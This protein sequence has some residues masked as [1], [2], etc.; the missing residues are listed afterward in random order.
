MGARRFRTL[1]V[2]NRRGGGEDAAGEMARRDPKR[3][4]P[5]R[6]VIRSVRFTPDEWA[7][8]LGKAG[9]ARL[10]PARFLRLAALGVRLGGR[11]DAEAVRQLAPGG[12]Q[13]QPAGAGGA[14]RWGGWSWP[15]GG[16]GARPGRGGAAGGWCDRAAPAGARGSG[17]CRAICSTARTGSRT[18]TGWRGCRCAI[19]RP[20]IRS[21]RRRRWGRRRRR[22]SGWR[23]RSTTCRSR[24]RRGRS[25]W[26]REEWER[27]VDR[28]LADLGLQEHQV[29]VVAHRRPEHDHVHLLIN[30]VHPE[31]LRAWK[32][33][34]GL[35]RGSSDSLRQIE[36]ELGLREV[37]GR[38][39]RLAGQERPAPSEGRT[40]GERREAERT[41]E[42]PWRRSGCGEAAGADLREAKSWAELEASAAR[43][44]GCGWRRKGRGLVVTDG[45]REVK[46]SRVARATSRERLERRFGQGFAEWRELRRE[47]LA[48]V[49]AYQ[50]NMARRDG[51]EGVRG[52]AGVD[53]IR[54]RDALEDFRKIQKESRATLRRIDGHLARAYRPEDV[55]RARRDLLRVA[56]RLGWERTAQALRDR[57]ERFG[58]LRGSAL[59]RVET[60]A[61]KA[62]RA[63]VRGAA[64]QV[65]SFGAAR[66]ALRAARMPVLVVVGPVPP[67]AAAR[68]AGQQQAPHSARGSTPGAAG[69]R[70]GGPHRL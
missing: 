27:V 18:R 12:Q 50:V 5:H 40:P 70:P 68:A 30:R 37:P 66:A 23:S 15:A 42:E 7:E 67:V 55:A 25:R 28:V 38:H 63:A 14:T 17:G 49:Q 29:M 32:G 69:A 31:R 2:L 54:A 6:T 16:R 52:A 47:F 62:A 64:G 60:A 11:V 39:Y 22:A 33:D 43:G 48:E 46:A 35:P 20:T 57:P 65:P 9:E 4:R 51:L 56:R 1:R 41:G 3:P 45:E 59:G 8:V 34:A 36:R 13:P 10:S 53:G 24:W 26:A 58:R 44:R 19:C 21:G 61:R